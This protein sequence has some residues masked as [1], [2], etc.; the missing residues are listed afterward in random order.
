MGSPIVVEGFVSPRRCME[1]VAEGEVD[2]RHSLCCIHS[3]RLRGCG[4]NRPLMY[5][6]QSSLS[7]ATSE[8]IV[9][10]AYS[11]RC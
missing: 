10:F 4:D 3:S 7:K 6:M 8:L 11:P 2:C 1:A 5:I 9:V